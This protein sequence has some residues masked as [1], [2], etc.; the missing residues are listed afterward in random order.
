MVLAMV[1]NII[2]SVIAIMI[3]ALLMVLTGC[4]RSAD[5]AYKSINWESIV[6]IGAM[7]PMATA[8]EKQ[9]LIN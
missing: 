9:E 4:L 8:F 6:L 2:P 7:L 1:F 3:A 5:E